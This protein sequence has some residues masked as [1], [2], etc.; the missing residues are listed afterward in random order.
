MELFGIK[1]RNLRQGKGLTQEQLGD[2][3]NLVKASVSGYEQD[4]TYPSVDVLI[5]LCQFFDVS[6]DYLLG[7]SDKK[8]V[9]MSHLTDEQI[10]ILTS[11][12]SQFTR[13]NGKN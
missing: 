5:K 2:R 8:E 1:L 13:L 3:L 6:A 4:K 7:L 11:L 10:S 12:I 9:E